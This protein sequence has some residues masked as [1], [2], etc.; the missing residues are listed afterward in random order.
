MNENTKTQSFIVPQ[1]ENELIER[2]KWFKQQEDVT[3]VRNYYAL[4]KMIYA[5]YQKEYG[6]DKQQ[7][8]ANETGFSKSTLYKCRQ[9]AIKYSAEKADELFKGR[10]PLSWRVVASNLSLEADDFLKHYHE[11]E[12]PDQLWNALQNSKKSGSA[13]QAEKPAKEK[14]IPRTELEEKIRQYEK[15]IILKDEEIDD[16]KSQN[17]K[18]QN[19]IEDLMAIN[20][21]TENFEMVEMAETV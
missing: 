14:K 7:K 18:L 20:A 10:F 19:Q 11:A 4:G 8:L 5:F 3:T 6:K 21:V 17:E 16:L 13:A 15:L 9:F 2:L 12:T 1:N